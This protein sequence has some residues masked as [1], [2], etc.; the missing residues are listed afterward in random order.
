MDLI[1]KWLS[2][3]LSRRE[4]LTLFLAGIFP[5]DLTASPQPE[6]SS[7]ELVI[8]AFVDT[9]I[10]ADNTTP[11]ASTLGV[12]LEITNKTQEDAA[13]GRFIRLGCRWLN[14]QSG[15]DFTT[16]PHQHQTQVIEWME[17]AASHTIPAQFFTR[18][19]HA[20]MAHY[21]SQPASWKG[22]GLN[23]PPQPLGHMDYSS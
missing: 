21:Y 7:D 3:K 17:N 1:R 22:L 10:P 20:A 18:I 16:L 6:G 11:S 2:T 23:N 4:L 13:Y 8:R 14:Y 5:L 19:R 9:L 12:D 15:G